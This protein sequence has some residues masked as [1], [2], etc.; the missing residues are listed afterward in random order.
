M[1]VQF[2]FHVSCEFVQVFS[3]WECDNKNC[4]RG[5]IRKISLPRCDIIVNLINIF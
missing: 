4:S 5:G 3:N 1:A 2:I